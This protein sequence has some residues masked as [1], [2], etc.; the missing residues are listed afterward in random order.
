MQRGYGAGTLG[1]W[2]LCLGGRIVFRGPDLL[3]LFSFSIPEALCIF[4]AFLNPEPS[5]LN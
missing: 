2:C 5:T 3:P 4:A 1:L